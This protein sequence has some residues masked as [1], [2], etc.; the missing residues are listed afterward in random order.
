MK[1]LIRK[2]ILSKVLFELGINKI[3]M[4]DFNN[5]LIYQKMI[6]IL[7]E[8]GVS[9]GYDYNWYIRGPYSP[10]LAEDL[11]NISEEL[12][13]QNKGLVFINNQEVIQQIKNTHAIL[14]DYSNNPYFLEIL[15]SLIYIQKNPS[16][17]SKGKNE[18]KQILL[19][20]KPMLKDFPKYD[21]YV[22]QAWE[23]M[24]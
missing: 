12:F 14:N 24:Q 3:D 20:K 23:I 22:D 10:Q 2:K 5:R 18:L 17:K 15:A 7:Q 21:E 9:L 13:N 1:D 16:A 8:K 4:R 11:F 19:T 6:Y